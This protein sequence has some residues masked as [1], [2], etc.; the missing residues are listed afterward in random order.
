MSFACPKLST[1][2][3]PIPIALDLNGLKLYFEINDCI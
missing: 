1:C 3:I 2:A